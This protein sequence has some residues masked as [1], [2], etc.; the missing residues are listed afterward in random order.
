[1]YKAETYTAHIN[2]LLFEEFRLWDIMLCSPLK[3][4]LATYFMLVSCLAYFLTLKVETPYSTDMSVDFQQT[5]QCYIREG[6]TFDNYFCEDLK[7][8]DCSLYIAA[9]RK[10]LHKVNIISCQYAMHS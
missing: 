6:R 7:S 2:L 3:V 10:A 8:Y 9:E 5:T 1:M 4:V